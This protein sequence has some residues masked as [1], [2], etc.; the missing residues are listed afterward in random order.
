[1]D[2]N[3]EEKKTLAYYQMLCNAFREPDDYEPAVEKLE[4]KD[5]QPNDEIVA[6]VSAI[7]LF[8]DVVS[9]GKLVV[10]DLLEMTYVI[11]RAVVENAL[12][13]NPDTNEGEEK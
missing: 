8:L 13:T 3:R 5:F 1:M 10:D 6:M 4:L 12:K 11:N 9:K 2:L 7:R